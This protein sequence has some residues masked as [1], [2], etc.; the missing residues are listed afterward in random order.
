MNKKIIIT[1]AVALAIILIG[2]VVVF[3][4]HNSNDNVRGD[5]IK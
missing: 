1:I 3:A 5:E 2:A 4:I